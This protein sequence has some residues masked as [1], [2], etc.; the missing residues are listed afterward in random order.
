MVAMVSILVAVDD[1]EDLIA[2]GGNI[3]CQD[4]ARERWGWCAWCPG[5]GQVRWH[6]GYEWYGWHGW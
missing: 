3:G 6:V 2:R 5:V 1:T 4:W